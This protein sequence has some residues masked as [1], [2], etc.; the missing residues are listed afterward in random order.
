[1]RPPVVV[2]LQQHLGVAVREEAV[3]LAGQLC[4]QCLV[5]VDAAVPADGQAQFG[6]G[7]R[8]GARLGQVDDL[9]P[10]VAQ[11]H[12][13]A[14]HTPEPSG[15]RRDIVCAI[16]ATAATSGVWPSS[17]TSPVA[18]HIV[19]VIPSVACVPLVFTRGTDFSIS[20]ET[21][22]TLAPVGRLAL[23]SA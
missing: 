16:A 3:A 5:V 18:P 11:R 15:P 6:I 13:P 17:R 12:P 2:G 14:D 8:L 9:Q 22:L 23:C 10:P 19:A 21:V 1:M 20:A 7:H 4:A